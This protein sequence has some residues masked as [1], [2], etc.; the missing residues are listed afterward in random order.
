MLLLLI[1]LILLVLLVLGP[2]GQVVL[3]LVL[4]HVQV[5]GLVEMIAAH[6]HQVTPRI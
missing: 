3:A 4:L 5:H 2:E 1:L 6:P